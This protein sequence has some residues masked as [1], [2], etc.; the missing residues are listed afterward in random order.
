MATRIHSMVPR[1]STRTQ[2][3]EPLHALC[4]WNI[5][6]PR[7]VGIKLLIFPSLKHCF[8]I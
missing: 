1:V 3:L 8:V 7:V 2:R 6:H 5:L 4:R